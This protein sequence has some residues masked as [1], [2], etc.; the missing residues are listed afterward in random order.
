MIQTEPMTEAPIPDLLPE[1]TE[2][3]LLDV[4]VLLLR[5][6]R[7]LARFVLG[8]ALLATVIA[9][10]LPVRYEAKL[11]LMPPQQNAA[12]VAAWIRD[13]VAAVKRH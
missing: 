13:S 9:F 1:Q 3:S 2:V 10:V 12:G 8:T 5:R 6:K 4:L 11:V 7:F